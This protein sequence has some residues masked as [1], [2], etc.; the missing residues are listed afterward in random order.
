[1]FYEH[2][3]IWTDRLVAGDSLLV[4]NSLLKKEGLGGQVQALYIDPPYGICEDQI[5]NHTS[6]VMRYVIRMRI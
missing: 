2:R 3:H 1:M 5:F 4:M 6:I